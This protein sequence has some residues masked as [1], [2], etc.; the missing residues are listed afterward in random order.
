M[1]SARMSG[2]RGGR[3]PPP[4]YLSRSFQRQMLMLFGLLALV[5]V[6]MR[7][8]ARPETWAWMWREAESHLL[9]TAYWFSCPSPFC[10]IPRTCGSDSSMKLAPNWKCV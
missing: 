1:D 5:L 8:A 4:D 9:V 7:V 3:R 10:R 2:A 6:L